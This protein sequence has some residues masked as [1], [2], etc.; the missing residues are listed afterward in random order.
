MAAPVGW[1]VVAAGDASPPGESTSVACAGGSVP[2]QSMLEGCRS[3]AHLSPRSLANLS[4]RSLPRSLEQRKARSALSHLSMRARIVSK[5]GSVEVPD[6]MSGSA[7]TSSSA[8]CASLSR[9]S[10]RAPLFASVV[11]A[12]SVGTASP[13][14]GTSRSASD[15]RIC[16]VSLPTLTDGDPEGGA[17]RGDSGM[18]WP[19][20]DPGTGDP[21]QELPNKSP[22][23]EA[24]SGC[25]DCSVLLACGIDGRVCAARFR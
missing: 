9:G 1:T 11:S 12:V 19:P 3:L 14:T 13:E 18:G 22:L 6:A 21:S 15:G 2:W 23:D 5:S 24:G 8:P 16:R 4:T 10:S 20:G 17:A 7:G 25:G